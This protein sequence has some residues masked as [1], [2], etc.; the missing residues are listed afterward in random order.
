M[1]ATRCGAHWL[2]FPAVLALMVILGSW[3]QEHE[4]KG[5]SNDGYV[6]PDES[7]AEYRVASSGVLVS[8]LP[9][10]VVPIFARL[11]AS[12]HIMIV[13]SFRDIC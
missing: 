7:A 6:M 4:E 10:L 3:S 5:R 12:L 13:L 2:G 11:H 1:H 8:A 9:M